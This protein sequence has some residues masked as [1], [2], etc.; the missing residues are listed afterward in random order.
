MTTTYIAVVQGASLSEL[1]ADAL[2]EGAKFFEVEEGR[3]NVEQMTVQRSNP[4]SKSAYV[5]ME[6]VYEATAQITKLPEFNHPAF[7]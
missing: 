7:A 6:V 5:Q 3:L 4:R 1:E 2:A